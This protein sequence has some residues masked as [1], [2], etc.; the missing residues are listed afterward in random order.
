MSSSIPWALALLQKYVSHACKLNVCLHQT[1]TCK[2]LIW[3]TFKHLNVAHWWT[4][5]VMPIPFIKL[6][7]ANGE[8]KKRTQ[9]NHMSRV[10]MKDHKHYLLIR[11]EADLSVL[12]GNDNIKIEWSSR[13]FFLKKEN[14]RA[15]NYGKHLKQDQQEPMSL[16]KIYDTNHWLS[17]KISNQVHKNMKVNF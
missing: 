4:Y 1:I 12:K 10:S 6:H 16:W 9:E 3:K 14:R 17:A 5:T 13:F 2:K 7:E 15:E 11:L 8:G